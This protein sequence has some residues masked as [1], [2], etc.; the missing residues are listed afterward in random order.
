MGKTALGEDLRAE[1]LLLVTVGA[2]EES[3]CNENDQLSNVG[4][5]STLDRWSGNLGP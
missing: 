4:A 1:L 3:S 2:P 5:P